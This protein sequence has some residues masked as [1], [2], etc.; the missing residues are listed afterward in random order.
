[1]AKKNFEKKGAEAP[2]VE[3]STTSSASKTETKSSNTTKKVDDGLVNLLK[4]MPEEQRQQYIAGLDPNRRMDLIRVMH[5]TFRT[6]PMA[7]S[8]TGFGQEAVNSINK[9]NASWCTCM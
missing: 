4:G 2:K 9:I 3:N 6:D 8:H 5:E 7:A 1:M